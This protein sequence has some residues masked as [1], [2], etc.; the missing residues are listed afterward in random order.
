MNT[1][2]NKISTKVVPAVVLDGGSDTTLKKVQS[3]NKDAQSQ[4]NKSMFLSS[5]NKFKFCFNNKSW[6]V[7]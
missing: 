3:E 4:D 1:V 2:Q 7:L 5:F 6:I